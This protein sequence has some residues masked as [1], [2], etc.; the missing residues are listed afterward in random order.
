MPT[1]NMTTRVNVVQGKSVSLQHLRSYQ[2]QGSRRQQSLQSELLPLGRG[3]A[4]TFVEPG[5]LDY[6]IPSLTGR[7]ILPLWANRREK[8]KTRI[9]TPAFSV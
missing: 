3:E 9:K 7:R 4:E 8:L 6:L 5:R 2:G 1:A